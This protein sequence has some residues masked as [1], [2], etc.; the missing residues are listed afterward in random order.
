MHRTT[1]QFRRHLERLSAPVQRIA[2]RNFDLLKENPRHP[3][4]RFGKV[5]RHWSA[6]VGIAYRVLAIE[7]GEDFIWVWIGHHSEY[8]RIISS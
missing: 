7:D 3:S 5:G 8:D 1:P 2:R 4:L 6:R